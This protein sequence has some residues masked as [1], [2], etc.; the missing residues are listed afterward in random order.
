LQHGLK[1][2]KIKQTV[3]KKAAQNKVAPFKTNYA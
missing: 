2:N 3:I 1:T